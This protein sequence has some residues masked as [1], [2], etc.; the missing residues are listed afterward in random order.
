MNNL[1]KNTKKAVLTLAI[2]LTTTASSFAQIY[3]TGTQTLQPGQVINDNIIL[4]GNVTL[5]LASG[6]ATI[7]GSISGGFSVTKNGSGSLVLTSPNNSYSGATTINGGYFRLSDGGNL[8]NTSGVI[9]AS[10][11]LEFFD[12][13]NQFTFTRV[14][15]GAG[16]IL[17]SS[18]NKV[19]LTAVNTYTGGTSISIW[20]VLQVGNGTS[21]SISNTSGVY[22]SSD[23]ACI[24]FEPG[25]NMTFDKVIS[26]EGRLEYK[27][28]DTK[29]LLLTAANPFLGTT[30]V[31]TGRFEVHGSHVSK[32]ILQGSSMVVFSH[33]SAYTYSGVISG[34]GTV[35]KIGAGTLTF[36]GVNTYTGGTVVWQGPLALGTYGTI[37][38]SAHVNL[39]DA[40]AKLNISAGNKTIK[41]IQSDSNSEVVLGNSRLFLGNAG[42]NDGGG[43]FAG[44]F[45]GTGS[46]DKRGNAM[47]TLSGASTYSGNTDI[48][49]GSILFSNL[50]NFGTSSLHL[51]GGTIAW[52]AGNTADISS[53]IASINN[54]ANVTFHTGA[55]NV[56]F[57]TGL[58][59]TTANITKDG[60]GK[61]TMTAANNNSGTLTVA[62]G[63]LQI[64]NGTS[65]SINNIASISVAQ[66][67][68]I[69][70]EPG[71]H[72]SLNKL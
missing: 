46:I 33:S 25:A 54:G 45:T 61:L 47:L 52:N 40:A 18:N 23:N 3:W 50:N 70:F 8:T 4:T 39:S 38:N 13:S 31:E 63:T 6:A 43:T 57:A 9:V 60:A 21:G 19:T 58:P 71:D 53:R 16:G 1:I 12:Q 68:V 51:Y 5:E 28:D 34:S 42:I 30:T 20:T 44:R 10:G 15:S 7:N 66:G 29:R 64:G 59:T 37:E 49:A 55:N 35:H 11:R 2:A 36:N 24:R 14:I 17:V 48:H 41:G 62:V 32:I 72:L 26:G 67:A 65:G 69:R 27:G 22:L 56:T